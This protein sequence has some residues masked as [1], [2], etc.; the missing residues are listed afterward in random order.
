MWAL[1]LVY[2]TP[3][4]KAMAA[5]S[6]KIEQDLAASRTL[7]EEAQAVL[8]QYEKHLVEV[9]TKSQDIITE[10]VAAAQK[11]RN[12]AMS[13]VQAD[14][15]DRVDAARK[16]LAKEKKELVMQLVDS[17]MQIVDTIM[18]KLIGQS[19]GAPLDRA[20]V[21]RAIEEAC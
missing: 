15:R 2:V 17:E 21:Q 10:A 20:K 4:A 12:E 6:A 19:S 1:D 16:V 9:R 5:R 11:T 7:Q 14:G 13:K 8:A 18:Q 3:V